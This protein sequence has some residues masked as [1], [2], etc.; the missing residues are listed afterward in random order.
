MARR[1]WRPAGSWSF[2]TRFT[3]EKREHR[4]TRRHPF[5]EHAMNGVRD[6]HV[7]P[8]MAGEVVRCARGLHAFGDVPDLR[9][10]RRQRLSPRQRQANPPVAREVARAGQYE[11]AQSGESRQRLSLAAQRRRQPAGF[12]EAARDQ[13]RAGIVAEAQAIA[14]AR[15][16]GEHVLHGASRFDARDIVAR[17]GAQRIAAKVI[18]REIGAQITAM[19]KKVLELPG[20]SWQTFGGDL[21]RFQDV[22]ELRLSARKD[23]DA[24]IEQLRDRCTALR[25]CYENFTEAVDGDHLR[26]LIEAL[27][28]DNEKPAITLSTVH[29]AKGLENGR[30]FILRPERMPLVWK[31][32]TPDQFEQEMNLRYVAITRAQQELYFVEDD[33]AA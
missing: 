2:G 15:S 22:Q 11:I 21:Q 4:V 10:D 29:R 17:V 18:G 24:Q 1:L 33:N 30:I 12:R 20:A 31:G 14:R 7:D 8:E 32:Q 27:F 16:D 19:I 28:T 23:A 9:E 3:C 13:R 6:R 5:V 25:A 26:A